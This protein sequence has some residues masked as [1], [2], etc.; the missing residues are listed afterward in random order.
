MSFFEIA[1]IIVVGLVAACVV[2]CLWLGM[3]QGS[4]R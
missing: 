3:T 4:L 1:L 2:F